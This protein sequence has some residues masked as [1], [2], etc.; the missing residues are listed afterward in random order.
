VYI[1]YYRRGF[2]HLLVTAATMSVLSSHPPRGLEPLLGM[3]VAFFWLYNIVDAARLASLYNDAL[4]GI[5]PEDLRRELVLLGR[6]GTIGGGIVLM[7][8]SL[9]FLLHTVF[10]LSLDWLRQWWPAVP[11]GYGAYLLLQGL[12]EKKNAA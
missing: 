4:A 6:R 2:T 12:R 3:F 1:G 10:G 7:A 9:L 8:A 5:G 11:L